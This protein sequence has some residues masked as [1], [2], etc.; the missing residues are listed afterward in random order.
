MSGTVSTGDT[1]D[2]TDAVEARPVDSG[3][4]MRWG[5]FWGRLIIAVLVA[6]AF[7]TSAVA[8][9]DR[10]ITEKVK[11]IHRVV[12]LKLAA[13]PPGGANYLIIG[14]D[15]RA[16]VD[17]SGDAAAF[18]DPSNPDAGVQGQRSDTIM[19]A[20]V[21]PSAQRTFVVSFP[22]DLMVDIPG[23][24]GKNQINS[25]YSLGGAQLVADTLK[26]NFDIEI[27][28]YLEV[29]FK[30]FE[31]VVNVI[32]N[33]QVYIPG[34]ARDQETGLSTPFGAGCYPLDGPAALAYVRAR[35]IEIA[36]PNGEIVDPDTGE[37]WTKL[38][39]WSD[40][41]RIR[42]QQLFIRKLAGLAISRSLSD[43]F[44]ALDLADK[45]LGYVKADQALSRDDV[46]ALVRAFK[47]V[48]VNDQN[49]IRFETLPIES[50]PPDPNRV[51]A[52]PAADQVV[53]QLRTFGDDV[54]KPPTVVPSQVKVQVADGSGTN[55]GDSTV[56]ALADQG[57]HATARK[58]PTST[59]AV[60]ELRYGFG[61]SEEAELLLDYFPDAKLV[62]DV[63][64][65]DSVVL[66]LGR[67]FP[68]TI[69]V[70]PTTTTGPPA[71][72]VPGA[73]ATQPVTTAPSTTT[74]TLLPED[75]CPQ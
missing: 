14:S 11:E 13:A 23:Y 30:S 37:H 67:S 4:R 69:T 42:R 9:V 65:K 63:T 75:N 3:D 31:A 5:G 43:P 25:A 52:S 56:K 21:E 10:S 22:R 47:T 44:L 29:D 16:F 1:G 12:G 73:P 32:G 59:V 7:M 38:D 18:G 36:D 46:N 50:Y 60:T 33:V 17:N 45:V 40:L 68:G 2:P 6:S 57:F 27:N 72:T 70:P 34:R 51:Q 74:T 66:V 41:A 24:Q 62:P 61:Q 49:S 55:V 8:L 15:T 20:H 39:D 26:A 35:H 48:N 53:E 71:S 64:A 54:P 58:A 28:H 19:V